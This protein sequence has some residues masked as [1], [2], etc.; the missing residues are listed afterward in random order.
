[1]RIR[2]QAKLMGRMFGGNGSSS[3]ADLSQPIGLQ[4]RLNQSPWDAMIFPRDSA[5]SPYQV[6]DGD[7]SLTANG[8]LGDSIGAGESVAS[9]KISTDRD[10]NTLKKNPKMHHIFSIGEEMEKVEAIEEKK[11]EPA[12]CCKSD[13]KGWQCKK[14]AAAGHSLCEHHLAQLRAYNSM[15]HPAGKKSDKEAEIRR[16]PRARKP[17]AAANPNEFYYYSGFGPRWGKRRGSRG[18]EGGN[19]S[20]AAV[21]APELKI[22]NDHPEID[23]VE[24]DESDDNEING[25]GSNES[26]KKRVRKPIKARSL[27]SLM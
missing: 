16:R 4:C 26:G 3:S 9:L 20:A 11:D 5:S 14:A 18:E 7:D 13:G 22:D 24:D 6:V 25:E 17:T 15:S 21:A 2:K 10:E 8:S 19:S 23:Y 1:M 12:L 27:K